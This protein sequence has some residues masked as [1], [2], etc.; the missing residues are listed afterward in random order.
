LLSGIEA[1]S[2]ELSIIF[3]ILCSTQTQ[4]NGSAVKS[5]GKMSH[6]GNKKSN[7]LASIAFL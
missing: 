4:K 1:I 2:L 6:F 5:C 3:D 7:T